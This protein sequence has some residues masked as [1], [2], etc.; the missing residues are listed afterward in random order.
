LVRAL[1]PDR[2]LRQSGKALT[3]D[4]A[5]LLASS[6]EREEELPVNERGEKVVR[7]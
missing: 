1:I 7:G 3:P 6:R 2:E 5:L 4:P